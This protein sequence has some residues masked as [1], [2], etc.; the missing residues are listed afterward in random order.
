MRSILYPNGELRVSGG[1]LPVRRAKKDRRS[2]S[3]LSLQTCTNELLLARAR[4]PEKREGRLPP[5][6]GS[7]P[8]RRNFT[9]RARRTIARCGGCF[10]PASEGRLV[11]LTGT[12]PGGTREAM[13][14]ISRY[15]SWLIH[16][17]LLRIQRLVR[18]PSRDLLW[19]W[20]WEFQKRGALHWHAAIELPSP[21]HVDRLIGGFRE[22]W[23]GLLELLSERS[24][25]DVFARAN[26]GT[27]RDR[28]SYWRVDA[29]IARSSPSNYLAK[30]LGKG[31]DADSTG[32]RRRFY[33]TRW[34]QCSRRLLAELRER[35]L[36]FVFSGGAEQPDSLSEPQLEYLSAVSAASCKAIAFGHPYSSSWTCVF[37]PAGGHNRFKQILE[38]YMNSEK[39]RELNDRISQSQSKQLFPKLAT[40]LRYPR[41][42]A[43]LYSSIG[44]IDRTNLSDYERGKPVPVGELE[45]LEWTAD[46]ILFLEGFSLESQGRDSGRSEPLLPDLPGETM[47]RV[48]LGDYREMELFEDL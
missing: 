1:S 21:D 8:K 16:V 7:L 24:G 34:Y 31:S 38:S 35:T 37:Y 18:V 27:W 5:G 25:V 28:P 26:G 42:A 11:F 4:K 46:K 41:V 29:Q 15:S 19:T 10:A 33:P 13:Q 32:S 6:Y 9:L 43:R 48:S 30:Y 44:S 47:A 39:N 17:L 20:V 23:G 40:A 2:F 45:F 14:A 36:S 12:L 22:A 3:C